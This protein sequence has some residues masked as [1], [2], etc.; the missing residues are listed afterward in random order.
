MS[1]DS[2]VDDRGARLI[3]NMSAV[4]WN[5]MEAAFRELQRS[6]PLFDNVQRGPLMVTILGSGAV[7]GAAGLAA[8]RYGDQDLRARMVARGVR[9]VE[10]TLIDHD[11]TW[12]ER[13][14]RTRLQRTDVLV[15]ATRR[16]EP[17][18]PI[19]RNAWIDFLP[20]HA[21]ILDLAADPYDFSVSPPVVKG[22]EGIPQ[23]NLD[24]F[25]FR[26][27]DRAYEELSSHVDTSHRRV[28]LSC[29]SW[30]GIHPRQCMEHY[31]GQLEPMM[32]VVLS[33]PPDGWELMSDNHIERA[34]KRAEVTT[35]A[36]LSIA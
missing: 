3:E 17:T 8:T 23:G 12:D 24:H 13:Y 30:P 2:I 11:L 29:Y 32:E 25:V 5:G 22:I 21:V 36:Q 31:E 19:I 27:D 20:E 18:Q 7:A 34:I 28:A 15:D 9:G 35:W 26:V 6:H 16:R 4:G 33:R 1:L 14:L 10:V